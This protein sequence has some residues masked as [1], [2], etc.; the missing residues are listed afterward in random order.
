MNAWTESAGIDRKVLEG[1]SLETPSSSANNR[2]IGRKIENTAPL[3]YGK[4]AKT[5]ET[6]SN[7]N[8]LF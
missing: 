1:L 5:K 2:I 6:P 8:L 4:S 3:S 7:S